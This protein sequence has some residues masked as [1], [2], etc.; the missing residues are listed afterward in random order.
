MSTSDGP[1]AQRGPIDTPFFCS[2]CE[3]DLA[4]DWLSRITAEQAGYP[5]CWDCCR[6][7]AEEYS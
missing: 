1:L 5:L 7:M 6:R 3:T 2:E 4:P